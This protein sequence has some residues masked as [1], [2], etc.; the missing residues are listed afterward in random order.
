MKSDESR[1]EV[2]LGP[3]TVKA[4]KHWLE[5]APGSVFVFPNESGKVWSYSNFWNRFWVPLMNRAGLVTDEPASAT[6]RNWSKAH[7]DFKQTRFDIH[8]LRHV[9][10]SLQIDQGVKP[11]R[12]QELMGHSTLKLTM[13]T[14]RHLW[15]ELEDDDRAAKVESALG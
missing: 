11:E 3:E 9:Y 1:R 15:P 4:L 7:A 6:V 14:Y 13:E 5:A 12:L 10:A 2:V 8:M